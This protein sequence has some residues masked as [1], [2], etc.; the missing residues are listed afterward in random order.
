MAAAH[1]VG[2][3]AIPLSTT[4]LTVCG[5]SRNPRGDQAL[6]MLT[7]LHAADPLCERNRAAPGHSAAV[8]SGFEGQPMMPA[9]VAGRCHG[10]GLN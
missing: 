9:T 7:L 6:H 4:A 3:P 10:W 2:N 1:G 8:S 5:L